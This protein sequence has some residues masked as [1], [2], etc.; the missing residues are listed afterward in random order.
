MNGCATLSSTAVARSSTGPLA[1]ILL[2][3]LHNTQQQAIDPK[4]YL[5]ERAQPV[6]Y[7]LLQ[8]LGLEVGA[9]HEH[10][11]RD[12]RHRSVRARQ[13]PGCKEAT[14]VEGASN[15]ELAH[16]RLQEREKGGVGNSRYSNRHSSA[17]LSN[18]C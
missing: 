9:L 17:K 1:E 7:H 10:Q 15:D 13:V 18:P 6:G 4:S 14:G 11:A 8:S 2:L 3:L 5:D 16:L 12:V